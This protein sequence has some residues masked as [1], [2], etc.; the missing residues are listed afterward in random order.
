MNVPVHK[1]A[2]LCHAS[3][4]LLEDNAEHERLHPQPAREEDPFRRSKTHS[5]PATAWASPLGLLN[6]PGIVTQAK[7]ATGSTAIAPRDLGNMVSRLVPGAFESAFWLVHSTV[8]PELWSL[9][10]GTTPLLVA[11]YSKSPVGTLLGRPVVVSE[12]AKDYNTAGDI[13]LVAP[14]GYGLVVK[15][16]GLRTDTTIAFGFDAGLQSFRATMR[17]G[18]QPLLSAP[19]ARKNGGSTQ[20]HVVALAAR[21]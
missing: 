16:S 21:S 4:E 14:E 11:D 18:G 9:V 6:G 7:S 15:S 17:I 19:V 12:S 13:M 3:D 1:V 5:W 20:G 2:G 8:L 10:L